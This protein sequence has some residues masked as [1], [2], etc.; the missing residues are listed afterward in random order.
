MEAAVRGESAAVHCDVVRAMSTVFTEARRSRRTCVVAQRP[1]RLDATT[2]EAQLRV[3]RRH[4]TTAHGAAD[5]CNGSERR[6]VREARGG[7]GRRHTWRHQRRRQQ[8]RGIG[9]RREQ[10]R[11]LLPTWR[12][13]PLQEGV[14][15]AAEGAGGGARAAGGRRRWGRQPPL[16]HG[17]EGVCWDN[18]PWRRVERARRVY[19]RALGVLDPPDARGTCGAHWCGRTRR[20]CA[21]RAGRPGTVGFVGRVR[22]ARDVRDAAA[23][24]PCDTTSV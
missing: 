17:L 5:R 14:A 23:A 12:A 16:S 20:V 11:P 22:C 24:Q 21:E 19:G 1:R 13:R 15:P 2:V 7:V 18:K 3:A 9:Q 6:L 10:V 8:Q 4:G